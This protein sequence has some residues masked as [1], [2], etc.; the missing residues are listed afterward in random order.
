MSVKV[1]RVKVYTHVKVYV[2][3]KTAKRLLIKRHVMAYTESEL[4]SC[5]LSQGVKFERAHAQ[6]LVC[7]LQEQNPDSTFWIR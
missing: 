2:F 7:D 6:A 1:N 5:D 3:D 4:F